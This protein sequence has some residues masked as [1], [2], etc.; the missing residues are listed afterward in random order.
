MPNDLAIDP[1]VGSDSLQPF[2]AGDLFLGATLLNN[3]EDDHAGAGRIFQFDKDG[4]QKAVLHLP[5]TTHL[6]KGLMF[7]PDGVLWGFD[8]TEHMVIQ[9]G[10]DGKRLPNPSY[11]ARPWSS[12]FFD[13]AGNLFLYEHI[14]GTMMDVP[15]KYRQMQKLLPGETEK[16]GDGNVYKFAP[17]GTLLDT[18]ETETS[19]SFAGFLGVTSCT[20]HP[21]EKYITYTTETSKRIMRYDI[22]NNTQMDDLV[23]LPADQ[24]EFVFC[25]D[26]MADGNLLV[27]RGPKIEVLDDT[28]AVVKTYPLEGRGWATIKESLDHDHMLVS[29][30]FGGMVMKMSKDTGEAVFTIKVDA[31][32]SLAGVAE[33]PG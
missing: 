16:I 20:L 17:D 30:F 29:S 4:T 31:E 6:V 19:T 22:V 28:G 3:P 11:P 10:P 32:R 27:T 12:G 1:D 18:Y 5:D 23:Q 13:K 9:V 21:S 33:F 24:P 26:Y 15:E 14:T 2:A 7:G 25:L 8:S